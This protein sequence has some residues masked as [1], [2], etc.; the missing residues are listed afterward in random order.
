MLRY[1]TKITG[2]HTAV[3]CSAPRSSQVTN[4]TPN[5]S[6]ESN[7]TPTVSSTVITPSH[8]NVRPCWELAFL[9]TTRI[10][11]DVTVRAIYER[12]KTTGNV[13]RK[14]NSYHDG[15]FGEV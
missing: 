14:Y 9:A 11:I 15:R 7:K 1:C 5:G 2:R 6:V 8:R 10:A 3:P 4:A 13:I 12:A